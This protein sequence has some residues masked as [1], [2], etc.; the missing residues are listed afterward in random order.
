[1]NRFLFLLPMF[2]AVAADPATAADRKPNVLLIIL[3]DWGPYLGCYGQ[4]F[5][6][7]PNLDQLAAEG[8][9][10]DACFS[11]APVCSSGRSS[12][13]TGMSQYSVH[14]EQHR[15]AD[16]KPLPVGVK[17]LPEL[18]RDA[19]YFTA[20]GCGYSAK[21]DLNFEFP[22]TTIYLGDD[23]RQRKPGQPF[24]AHLTLIGTHR[25]WHSD[26]A[27]PIDPARVVLPPWYPETLLT[28][29]D[30]A[31]GL[32]SAQN[33]DRLMGEIIA[34]LKR[35]GIYDNTA[36]VI[37]ADH[38]VALPRAK[39]FL[40][41]EG[42]HIPLIIRWPAGVKPG[43]SSADL[44]SNVDIVPTVLGIADVPS[45]KYLQGRNILDPASPSRKLIFAGRDKMDS[46]HDAMRAARS[47]DFKYILNLMPER[48]YCQFNDYKER[49][50]PGLAVLNVLHLEGKLSPEQDAFMQPC[51]PPEELYDLRKDAY[52]IHNLA[53]DPPYANILDSMRSELSDWRKSVGDPGVSD[54]FRNG[55]WSAKY[56]TRSLDEWK[57][58][59]SQWEEHILRGGPPPKIAAP[60]GYADGDG[61]VKPKNRKSR[62]N[63][64]RQ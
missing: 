42:L 50:Y 24:F 30:W 13:M 10:Y 51:K 19:G 61:M 17:S 58:I 29:K 54:E 44:V 64:V 25:P 37:T 2:V 28:R 26:P 53:K 63:A 11:S 9:R 21:I 55:G 36:I 16:K 40:Y 56:P 6:H 31:L 5:M 62:K 15:T 33:S 8:C 22:A 59:V 57:Q 27:R 38:G 14:S 45:P 4:K 18:L 52:E 43:T 47:K 34:R 32:E 35:E 60:A 23:W 46:T 49:S 41:D 12:L 7:T 20:L 3:E 39:Q 1:M 48:P